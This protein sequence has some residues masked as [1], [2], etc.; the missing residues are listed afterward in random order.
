M[1][2]HFTYS[3]L[4]LLIAYTLNVHAGTQAGRVEMLNCQSQAY[5]VMRG[6]KLIDMT[7]WLSLQT[8]DKIDLQ[9]TLTIKDAVKGKRRAKKRK[10]K[11]Q[12]LP[13]SIQLPGKFK[14]YDRG[15]HCEPQLYHIVRDGKNLPLHSD[16]QAGDK[17]ERNPQATVLAFEADN[18]K[19]IELTWQDFPY[20]VK[21]MGK[22]AT[23]VG[24][25][26]D[27]AKKTL[28]F[29]RNQEIKEDVRQATQRGKSEQSTGETELEKPGIP[30]L[31]PLM[32]TQLVAGQRAL[33]VGWWE[34]KAP[35]R[36]VIQPIG[37]SP[38]FSQQ[39]ETRFAKTSHLDL[40]KGKYEL[41]ITDANNMSNR[42]PFT[43]VASH[44]PYPAE[45]TKASDEKMQATLKALWLAGQMD[46][47][48]QPWLFEAYQQV[49]D[50]A[51]KYSPALV[52]RDGILYRR[53]IEVLLPK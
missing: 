31:S 16:V 13:Y 27:W 28:T 42:Y 8:G 50:I 43:V 30:M 36:L 5:K 19:I 20:T 2:T 25:F 52:T 51:D 14:I 24:N 17:I 35:Y 37:K 9:A 32:N 47:L 33:F 46:G 53:K 4:I 10:L 41:I 12:D 22:S 39:F 48:K 23:P 45:I 21:E 7:T 1:R 18:G 40:S 3:I 6:D 11:L 44:P 29:W 26:F 49:A 38:I 34:T 15:T